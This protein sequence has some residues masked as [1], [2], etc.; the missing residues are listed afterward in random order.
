MSKPVYMSTPNPYARIWDFEHMDYASKSALDM[1]HLPDPEVITADVCVLVRN[2][3]TGEESFELLRE[4]RSN[5]PRNT[6]II[7][8]SRRPSEQLKLP[9]PRK[10]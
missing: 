10:E 1:L 6:Y 2:S 4:Y 8:D 3:D 9:A 7:S 5:P